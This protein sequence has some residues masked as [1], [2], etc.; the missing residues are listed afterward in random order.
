MADEKPL[1]GTKASRRRQRKKRG[2][3]QAR[4]KREF[5][6][7]GFTME[8]LLGM[9]F[10]EVLGL[11][12]ARVRR[13]FNRGL[14]EEQKATYDKIVSGEID[15]V[16]THRRD[17]P[18][19]PSFVGKK[20]AIHNGKEFKEVEIKPEMIGHYLGEFAMTRKS[21]KHSGPGVG[22]TRSSKF[23]PLK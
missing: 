2:A 20:V 19:V 12:P 13:S 10:E 23:L 5:T 11:M 16:R 1:T 6:Y 3:I 21:V 9:P 8:E 15:V 22:A 4:R 14:N 18:I 17:I 7:R